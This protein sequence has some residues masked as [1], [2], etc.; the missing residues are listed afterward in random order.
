MVDGSPGEVRCL[1]LAAVV[2]LGYGHNLTVKIDAEG[3]EW[4]LLPH[5]IL[6]GVD[7][8]IDLLIV[9]WHHSWKGG[10]GDGTTDPGAAGLGLIERLACPVE[11]WWM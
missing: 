4:T 7:A 9:E 8:L 10:Y 3:A 6:K 1:D 5:L 11:P 2:T